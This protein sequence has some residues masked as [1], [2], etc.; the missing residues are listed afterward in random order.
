MTLSEMYKAALDKY[1]EIMTPTNA[2]VTKKPIDF[3]STQGG[4]TKD[5]ED[6]ANDPAMK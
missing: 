6:V 2:G 1:H 4:N 3:Q 5:A